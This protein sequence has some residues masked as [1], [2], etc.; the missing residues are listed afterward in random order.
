MVRGSVGVIFGETGTFEFKVM[1]FDSSKVYRGA[2]VKVWHDASS[3]EKDH[4]W[5]LG[6]VMAIKRYSDSFSIEE[7]M[8]GQRA[9]K[10]ADKIVAEVIIIGSRDET[11]MLR[12]PVIPFSPGSPIFAADE[13]LTRSVLGL[14]GNEMN[15]G[16]LEGTNIK[17]QLSVNS[18]VQKH[19][20]ILAKT[21]SGKSYTA[22]VLLEELLDQNIPMLII[23]PH[24]EYSS[25]KVEGEGSPEDF[26]RFGVKPK[27][28]GN[29]ITVYTPASKAINPDADELFRLNGMNLT[30]RDL[31]SVFPDNFSTTHTG[32]LY[33]A[34]Q[35]LRA[36]METY[37]IDDIIFEVGNDKSKAKWIV[38]NALEQIRD[39]NILSPNPTSISELFQ[40]GKAA[41]IDFKGVAP[42]L[43]SMIV[44]SLCSGLFE[45][46]KLNQIPPG[47]LVVEEAHNYAPEKGFSK[48]TSTDILRTIASEGRKFGLGMM[49]VS[50]RPARVDKN[51]LSQCGTQVIMKVTN[52]NDLKA[53][54]KGLEGVTSYVEEELMRL[55]PGV[56]MLVSNEIERPVLVDIRIRKSKHGGESVN[57]LHAARTHTPPPPPELIAGNEPSASVP[58]PGSVSDPAVSASPSVE[59]QQSND[60]LDIPVMDAP[61]QDSAFTPPPKR[62]PSRPPRVENR[63]NEGSEGG[64]KLFK[65]LFRANR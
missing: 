48:T 60:I 20:S 6:Q 32:I 29:N 46:R 4:T 12:A 57:V 37:T 51:V 22:S 63:D 36:E 47:M 54:S 25:L 8:K 33:E 39:T 59:T 62:K 56:A 9:D 19:C 31:T 2:Y 50:Q 30:V 58:A 15:I 41:V 16:M 28:Y 43:Q 21:G 18:L 40:K 44:A 23:D 1:V 26:K 34:I 17:V 42:E 10:S 11:G 53:I 35:K 7:A 3:D 5:V 65:K 38:I 49:V 55:P 13:G 45:A 27:G 64:G 14:T 24:S 61:V 52:P